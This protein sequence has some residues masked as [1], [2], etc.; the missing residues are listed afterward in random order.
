MALIL[1]RF[2]LAKPYRDKLS[3]NPT[4]STDI[5]IIEILVNPPAPTGADLPYLI[6]CGTASLTH[7]R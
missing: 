6:L 3:S 4:T 1:Q 7:K 2:E 5:G